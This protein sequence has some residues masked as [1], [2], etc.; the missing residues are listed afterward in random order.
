MKQ[1]LCERKS[2]E[3]IDPATAPKAS[4]WYY[5]ATSAPG[6]AAALE[7]LAGWVRGG[8]RIENG[9]HYPKDYTMGE[10]RHVLRKGQAPIVLSLLRTLVLMLLGQIQIAGLTARSYP[11]K[12][13]DLSGNVKRAL[14]L[15]SSGPEAVM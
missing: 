8:W 5:W 1:A 12:M 6:E 3:P 2:F 13:A 15:L 4:E 11:Q 10:D 9:L 7:E 14:D